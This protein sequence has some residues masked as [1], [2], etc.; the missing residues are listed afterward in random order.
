MS[1]N[2]KMYK[3]ITACIELFLGIPIVGGAIILAN[4]WWPLT[5]LLGVHILG[6]VMSSKHN[7]CKTGHIIGI[8]CNIIGVIPFVGMIMHICT[9][10]VLLIEGITDK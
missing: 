1:T 4:G 9:G 10:I 6:L 5:I 8:A 2:T 7:K 3:I